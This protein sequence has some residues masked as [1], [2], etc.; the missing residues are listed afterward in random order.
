MQRL[1][2][3][4]R[5]AG[6]LELYSHLA[7]FCGEQ[8]GQVRDR[9]EGEEIDKDDGL[10]RFQSGMRGAIGRNHGVV[11]QFQHRPVENESQGRNQLRPHPRQ[12]HAGHDDH[13]G[14]EKVQR[15][16]PSSGF[17]DHEA[18]QNQIG[19]NLQRGLQAMF[20]PQGEQEHV[21]QRKAAPEQHG[22]DE[23]P[24]GQRRRTVLGDRQLNG[25]QEGQDENPDPN[26]PH[27]PI[28]LVERRLHDFQVLG[29]GS[30]VTRVLGSCG[31]RP[32]T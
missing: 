27:Q 6:V 10:Q 15:A 26:Q 12:Q 23:E 11:V 30:E 17:M 19:E 4:E 25:Q 13:Q 8:S 28:A 24:H 20:L 3:F 2:A 22:T 5:A 16:V 14:I 32:C 29:P 31:L 18:D 9:Q 21:E 7:Q 1:Q